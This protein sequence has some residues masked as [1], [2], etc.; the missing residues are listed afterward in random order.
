M[1]ILSYIWNFFKWVPIRAFHGQWNM[2]NPSN[3]A[4]YSKFV[5]NTVL[6]N[7]ARNKYKIKSEGYEANEHPTHQEA[8]DYIIR[9]QSFVRREKEEKTQQQVK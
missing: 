7:P 6:F 2:T 3:G 9:V 8:I 4:N 5:S 1:K